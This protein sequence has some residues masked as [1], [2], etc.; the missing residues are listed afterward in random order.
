MSEA[1]KKRLNY[2][3]M[4]DCW[5]DDFDYVLGLKKE[6]YMQC[7]AQAKRAEKLEEISHSYRRLIQKALD[8]GLPNFVSQVILKE[9]KIVDEEA[10]QLLSKERTNG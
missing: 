8:S 7:I 1:E 2:D 4:R 6:E 10:R 5:N 9:I 3:R